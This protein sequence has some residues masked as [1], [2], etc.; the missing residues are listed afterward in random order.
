[1]ETIISNWK[2][3]WKYR[4]VDLCFLLI[5]E[6]Y[7]FSYGRLCK[8]FELIFLLM[9]IEY[10]NFKN[11][12]EKFTISTEFHDWFK[13][14][15]KN[16]NIH[17]TNQAIVFFFSFCEYVN[18]KKR[19]FFFSFWENERTIKT[20]IFLCVSWEYTNNWLN[21]IT[22]WH[23]F[24][25]GNAWIDVASFV[26]FLFELSVRSALR[27]V[28]WIFGLVSNLFSNYQGKFSLLE[29]FDTWTF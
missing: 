14:K 27:L 25:L 10:L 29:P 3:I 9:V 28:A 7:H 19:T 8:V 22:F 21:L 11:C 23:R 5:I 18:H 1:M 2:N 15:K 13:R 20:N 26:T 17:Y 12:T 24:L 6:C 16:F 4:K